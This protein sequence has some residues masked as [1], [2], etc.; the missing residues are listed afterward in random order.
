F[1]QVCYNFSSTYVSLIISLSLD[2]RPHLSRL[3]KYVDCVNRLNTAIGAVTVGCEPAVLRLQEAVEFLSRTKST[4]QLRIHRLRETLAAIKALYE[5][6]VDA[7][8]YE[9]V[10]DEALVRLQDEY[11]AILQQI[12]HEGIREAAEGG[13]EGD[14]DAEVDREAE[15]KQLGSE[16]EVEV[17]GRISETLASNDCLDICIDIYVKVRY[18][19]AAKALMRLNPR[20]LKTY[21][22]E[23]IDKIEWEVLESAIT[24]WIQHFQLAVNSVFLAEKHLCKRV[25]S[26]IMDGTIWPACFA[27]IADKIMAVFFR[28]GEGVARSSKEP[29]KLFKLLDMYDSMDKIRSEFFQVFDGESGVDICA[30]FRELQKLLVHAASKVFWEFGLQ[31]E[32]LEDGSPPPSDGSV[33]KIVR[34]AVNYLKCL[35]GC[36]YASVMGQALRIEKTWKAG[37]LSKAEPDENLLREAISNALDALQRNVEAKRSKYKDKTTSHVLAMNTYWYMYMR[38]RGSELAKLVGEDIMK[39]KYKAAAEEAAYSYQAQAWGPL[40]KWLQREEESPRERMEVFTREFE[41]ILRRHQ[42]CYCVQDDDLRHQIGGAVVKIVVPAYEEFLSLHSRVCQ[43]RSSV[44]A[45]DS[46]REILSRIFGGETVKVVKFKRREFRK[47]E[48]EEKVEGGSFGRRKEK[49]RG[50][51]RFRRK[52]RR[53]FGRKGEQSEERENSERNDERKE[54][55]KEERAIVHGSVRP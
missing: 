4:D 26:G 18:R 1:R 6:E 50:G 31:I 34:Y 38:T 52:E 2:N 42:K 41:E 30:R 40:V 44:L 25:L 53:S 28:F 11:E 27:K 49:E 10:F 17:L 20:Y 35:A 7:M 12:K 48:D 33:P 22:P 36:G 21:A 13:E 55:E 23:E 16:L 54:E 43:G 8:R 3:L 47:G 19:R 14:V 15:K 9:G 29:Q 24:L 5:S 45:P 46:M 51:E 37:Y 39:K 32:G